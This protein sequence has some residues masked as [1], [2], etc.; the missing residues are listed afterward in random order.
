MSRHMEL[1]RGSKGKER[2]ALHGSLCL[3]SVVSLEIMFT[4]DS[5]TVHKLY[6]LIKSSVNVRISFFYIAGWKVRV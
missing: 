1:I 5:S 4:W 2:E 6:A 3:Y